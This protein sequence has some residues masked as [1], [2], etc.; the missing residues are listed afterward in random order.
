METAF[1][2]SSLREWKACSASEIYTTVPVVA[3]GKSN[4]V[5]PEVKVEQTKVCLDKALKAEN[6]WV[7][8]ST[9]LLKK[10]VEK[11]DATAWAAYHASQKTPTHGLPAFCAILTLFYEKS[12][13]LAV[14]KQGMDV[15]KQATNLLNPGQFCLTGM[16][17]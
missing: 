3:V 16:P 11:R 8:N 15:V 5:V 12:A 17:Y 6:E 13:T 1:Y 4:T 9:R 2:G 14:I 10:E 7:Q